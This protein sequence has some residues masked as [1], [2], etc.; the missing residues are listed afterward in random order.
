MRVE[1]IDIKFP[2]PG[3][4][5]FLTVWLLESEGHFALVDPGP[6]SAVESLLSQLQARGIEK[7]DGILLTHI[8]IDHTGG[9][10]KLLQKI[11]VQWV[12]VHPRG[13]RHLVDPSRLWEGSKKV[14]GE[15]AEFYG[16]IEPIEESLLRYSERITLGTTSIEVIE[17]PGHAPHHLCFSDGEYLFA[18]DGLGIYI[19]L[20]KFI[21]FRP[22]TP[23]PFRADSY[24][25]SINLLKNLSPLPEKICFPHAGMAQ[26][27]KRWLSLAENQIRRWIDVVRKNF[28]L[29]NREVLEILKREDPYLR[30]LEHFPEGVRERELK[31]LDNTL[32]GIR[33]YISEPR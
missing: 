20:E 11:P 18:G 29:G 7:L 32:E 33:K 9:L 13:K 5:K 27:A 24:V 10:G 28:N 26:G 21:Y 3:F 1:P 14:L 12:L 8:H 17:T 15:L 25:A 6:S 4:D 19:D 31:F 22:A 2:E 23:P 16:P 30:P